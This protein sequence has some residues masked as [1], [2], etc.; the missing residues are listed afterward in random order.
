MR[1]VAV[2]QTIFCGIYMLL[3]S[4]AIL[5]GAKWEPQ[6]R[7]P[8][9]VVGIDKSIYIYIFL[10]YCRCILGAPCVGVTP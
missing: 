2:S 7:N 1:C 4:L 8:K 6:T 5:K 3:G 9:N 10:I